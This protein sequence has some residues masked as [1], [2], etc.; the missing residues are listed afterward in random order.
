[1]NPRIHMAIFVALLAASS[2]SSSIN[3][4]SSSVAKQQV[5]GLNLKALD[6]LYIDDEGDDDIQLADEA[7]GLGPLKPALGVE[8]ED[9]GEE[10]EDEE[11]VEEYDDNPVP[12]EPAKKA[13]DAG[14][15]AAT[16][17]NMGSSNKNMTTGINDD[18]KDDV[19]VPPK[20]SPV[21]AS[22]S[23][24]KPPS[25]ASAAVDDDEDDDNFDGSGGSGAGTGSNVDEENEEDE[26]DYD[27]TATDEDAIGGI[28]VNSVITEPVPKTT[29]KPEKKPEVVVVAPPTSPTKAPKETTQAPSSPPP[30][31]S[32][33]EN[34]VPVEPMTTPRPVDPSHGSPDG[35]R[36]NNDVQILD[37]KPDDRQASFFAQPG[38]LA[39]VIGG[40]VVGLLCAILLVM[41]IVYRMRKKDEGSY[42]LDE[43]KRNSPNSHPYNKN[44]REFYA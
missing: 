38:I 40:A 32:R 21:A 42:V 43:P 35:N 44:S 41:F 19:V 11:D 28:D 37:H 10:E 18:Y 36:G 8:D 39:A 29:M 22:P 2:V 3:S 1:M 17:T 12:V 6:D 26:D 30:S 5:S 4:A 20:V 9:E 27:E 24:G 23:S 34:Q 13:K 16:T 7:S 25:S 31:G 14:T 33:D 15:T